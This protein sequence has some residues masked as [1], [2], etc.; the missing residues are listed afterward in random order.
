MVPKNSE[1]KTTSLPPTVDSPV[2]RTDFSDDS[3][4]N[5]IC[6]AFVKPT[7]PDGFIAYVNFIED[8]AFENIYMPR[9][10][11]SVPKDYEHQFIIVV[12]K[13]ATTREDNAVLVV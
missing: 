6:A 10:L 8:R 1:A 7:V 12:D 5:D 3:K 11:A 2:L 9:L 4:W 13:L